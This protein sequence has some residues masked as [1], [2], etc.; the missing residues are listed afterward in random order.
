MFR[1]GS[2]TVRSLWNTFEKEFG[3]EVPRNLGDWGRRCRESSFQLSA[4]TRVLRYQGLG[5]HWLR[6]SEG[7]FE[8]SR[9]SSASFR[10]EEMLTLL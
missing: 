2:R 7:R 9:F 1:S 8:G 10:L 5:L 4:F 3:K 6:C